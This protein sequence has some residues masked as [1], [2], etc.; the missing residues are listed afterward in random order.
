VRTVKG[1]GFSF[2]EENP[3]A[4]HGVS[5]FDPAVGVTAKG[6]GENFSSVFGK[7]LTKL[8]E[9]DERVCAI[10][11][12]MLTGTGL[13]HY[14]THFPERCFDVGIA[15]E[16]AVSMAAGMA[17]QGMVP[18]FAVYSTFLQRAYD[19]L[20]HDVALDHLH[21]VLAVDRAGLVGEDG[22]THHGVF[23]VAFLTQIPGMT[24][25]VPAS[26]Q[27]LREML[28]IAVMYTDCPVAIRYP[29]G[30]EG[31]FQ[32]SCAHE[33]VSVLRSGTDVTLVSYGTLINEVISAADKLR[34]DGIF[35]EII[36]VNV[37][38]PI[39]VQSILDSAQKTGCI[40]IAEDVVER[41]SVGE[42]LARQL[43]ENQ[44]NARILLCNTG[45]HFTTHGSVPQ[46]RRLLE[47]DGE[48]L[49]KRVKEAL[50]HG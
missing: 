15:E 20:V 30:T 22:E 18:V 3:D 36:K 8:T 14:Q 29:R 13:E 24:V 6:T 43:A 28:E 46:L 34:Q 9:Q 25:F 2:A 33:P 44:V 19:M 1:K 26:Y 21:T 47:L 31:A 23:D 37:I 16:C 12:A 40:L 7:A 27:E 10:T 11:A 42:Y 35:A 5:A 49:S 45:N 39:P 41:G 17:K 48:G 50:R 38:A 32:D 4:Y